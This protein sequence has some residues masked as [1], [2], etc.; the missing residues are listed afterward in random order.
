MLQAAC[1]MT[2]VSTNK[3]Q[4]AVASIVFLFTNHLLID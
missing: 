4:G 2:S 3:I 1:Q